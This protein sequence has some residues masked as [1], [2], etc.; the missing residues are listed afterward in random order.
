MSKTDYFA[1]LVL[2]KY[3][4]VAFSMGSSIL[5]S[6]FAANILGPEG[7]GPISYLL[8]FMASLPNIFGFGAIYDIVNVYAA[9]GL[10]RSVM[11]KIISLSL[12]ALLLLAVLS[13]AFSGMF[14]S[15]IQNVDQV[16][17]VL[18]LAVLVMVPFSLVLEGFFS[19]KKNFGKILKLTMLEKGIDL[20]GLLFFLLVLNQGPLSMVYSKIISATVIAVSYALLFRKTSLEKKEIAHKEVK[21]F[22]ISSLIMNLV[23]GWSVQA[24]VVFLMALLEPRALGLFYLLQ[25]LQA[26][27][28]DTPANAIA[29]VVLPFLSEE[30]S[31]KHKMESYTNLV[32]KFQFILN[33][34]SVVI[35]LAIVPYVLYFFFPA[36]VG[37]TA[38]L[39]VFSI[40]LLFYFSDSLS[41]LAK[42]TNH[43]HMLTRQFAFRIVALVILAYLLIPPYGLLGAVI[44]FML[45]RVMSS[46]YMLAELRLA[47]F[48][49][50]FIP[51]LSDIRLFYRTST[52]LM[53]RIYRRV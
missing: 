23:K 26:Y 22:A 35:F 52:R 42:S 41:K 29:E 30:S 37:L 8:I 7:Y 17:F 50:S 18:A 4:S 46:F 20:V 16:S 12:G 19:G 51:R 10:M 15:A 14:S 11:S 5:Y 48:K 24:D 6:F 39:P 25:R 53:G 33:V 40:G 13:F 34:G 38:V 36:Y 27:V 1:K 49:L 32:L 9:K 21:K 43:N 3:S 44:V 28:I 31:N 2:F 47:G 45:L